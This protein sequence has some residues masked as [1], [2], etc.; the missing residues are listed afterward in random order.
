[1]LAKGKKIGA[2]EMVQL[3]KFLPHYILAG[4]RAWEAG[5]GLGIGDCPQR[6]VLAATWLVGSKS[7]ACCGLDG[8]SSVYRRGMWAF[9]P[10][11]SLLI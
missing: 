2:E 3:V 9:F 8:L 5:N 1:M 11:L 10:P 7:R 6:E 4:Y